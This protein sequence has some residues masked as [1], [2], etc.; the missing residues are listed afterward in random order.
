MKRTGWMAWTAVAGMAAAVG[1]A[2]APTRAVTNGSAAAATNAAAVAGAKDPSDTIVISCK[3]VEIPADAYRRFA[4]SKGFASGGL[5][6]EA[7]VKQILELK[8]LDIL[9]AP[10]VATLPGQTAE[11]RVGRETMAV[12]GFKQ[13]PQEGK[14][15]PVTGPVEVGL[16]LTVNAEPD[17]A[18]PSCLNT[19]V[20][21]VISDSPELKGDAAAPGALSVRTERRINSCVRIPNGGTVILGGLPGDAAPAK[22]P[23]RMIVVL[24]SAS[25]AEPP[26]LALCQS[27]ILPKAE[28]REAALA[29]VVAFLNEAARAN[30][31]AKKGINIILDLKDQKPPTITLVLRDIRLS[32][33]LRYVAEVSGLRVKF[34]PQAVVIGVK[35]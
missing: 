30:D 32:D 33:A 17:M 8:D 25:H 3:F 26:S 12:T 18:D 9:S 20:E 5:A 15:V 7:L 16:S 23:P 2:E 22:G 29:D 13:N 34:D 10:T 21:I 14:S 4:S 11:V 27:L 1:A 6:S 24:L 19:T 35:P 28:F 31:P